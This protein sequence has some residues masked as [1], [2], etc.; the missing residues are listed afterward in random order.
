[1]R[2]TCINATRAA[3]SAF[4]AIAE[5]GP[6]AGT[7]PRLESGVRHRWCEEAVAVEV[8]DHA[9]ALGLVGDPGA[10][11]GLPLLHDLLVAAA[12]EVPPHHDLLLERLSTEQH[13]DRV[14]VRMYGLEAEL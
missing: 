1:M 12:D 2:H 4:S 3:R 9:E 10:V 11:P 8:A 14:L 6:S 5:S 7:A 13:D